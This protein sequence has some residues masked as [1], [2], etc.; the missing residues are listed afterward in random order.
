[1]ARTP[2]K[3]P[4]R[5]TKPT[6]KRSSSDWVGP[7]LQA[8]A[9]TG[10]IKASCLAA[11][12]HRSTVYDRRDQDQEFARAMAHA[13]D[14]AVDDLEAEAW[15]RA[16]EGCQ[17]PVFYRGEVAGHT[18]EYSDALMALLLKAHRPEKYRERY[19]HTGPDGQPL[20]VQVYIPA[21][22]REVGP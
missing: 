22:G 4:R 19:E 15:R 5:P 6:R 13:L 17:R 2:K 3:K 10:N 8:L 11:R 7:F 20:A 1:M 14:D 12:V 16:R 21:N 9:R 18:I